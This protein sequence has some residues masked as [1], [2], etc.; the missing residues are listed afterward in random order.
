VD[1]SPATGARDDDLEHEVLG[2][3]EPVVVIQTALAADELRPLAEELARGG[4]LQVVHYHRR[5]YAGSGPANRSRSVTAESADCRALLDRL[6]VPAVHVVG[7]S[8]SAAI[9]LTLASQAPERVR[10]L[11][12]VEPP[13]IGVPSEPSFRAAN[14]RLLRTFAESGPAVALDAFLTLL[15]GPD[16]RSVSE[17][18]APGSV[19]AMERDAV[20]FFASDLP[21]LLSWDFQAEDAA[22]IACPVLYVGGSESGQWFAEVRDRM[23]RLLPQ[24]ESTTVEGAGHLLASTHPSEVARL[25]LGFLRRHIPGE[26]ADGRGRRPAA[27]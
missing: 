19:E 1:P 9:A 23:L 17:R 4:G 27:G 10:S 13:P 26:V 18:D 7:V 8:Y 14:A 3:G 24:A 11:T 6:H 15:V 22:R 16:W 21:A 25:V 5:G 12:V 20:T 2:E